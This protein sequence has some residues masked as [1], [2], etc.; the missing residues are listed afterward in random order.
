MIVILV[1]FSSEA[2]IRSNQLD[3]TA[4]SVLIT[5]SFT[6][7]FMKIYALVFLTLV[8]SIATANQK[9]F[10]L[11]LQIKLNKKQVA[12]PRV[13]VQDGQ[14]SSISFDT[15]NETVYLDILAQGQNIKRVCHAQF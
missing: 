7:D 14:A 13:I 12:S 6:G 1:E 5:I 8:A 10:D 4:E 3:L 2:K 15:P 11:D 9:E